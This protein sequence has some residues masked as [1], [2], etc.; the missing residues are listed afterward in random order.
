MTVGYRPPKNK[1]KLG[2]KI[3]PVVRVRIISLR[4]VKVFYLTPTVVYYLSLPL[5]SVFH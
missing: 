5:S 1:M 4:L 2:A 3:H